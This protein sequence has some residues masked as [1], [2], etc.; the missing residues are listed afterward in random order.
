MR[1][2]IEWQGGLRFKGSVDSRGLV[3]DGDS[4]EGCSPMETLMMALAG[5]MAIDIVHILGK[6]HRSIRAVRARI[7]GQRT[8][9]EPRRFTRLALHFEVEGTKLRES[10][11][12]RAIALSREK[13]CSVWHSLDPGIERNITYQL[14][15]DD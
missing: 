2:Q 5:C 8:E 11:V 12:E 1:A 9:T 13:Y 4:R 7:E 14:T 15:I 3:L 10:Q 6:M